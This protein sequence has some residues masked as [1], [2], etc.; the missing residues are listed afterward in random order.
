MRMHMDLLRRLAADKDTERYKDSR[1]LV[2][3]CSDL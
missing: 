2:C 3:Y 1:H